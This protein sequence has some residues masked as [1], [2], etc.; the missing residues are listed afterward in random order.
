MRGRGM[1]RLTRVIF[2]IVLV[3]TVLAGLAIL[4]TTVHSLFGGYFWHPL[5]GDGYQFWS[6]IGSDVGEITMVTALYIWIKTHNCHVRG[7]WR[8]KWH[9]HPDHGHPVCRRHHPHS[10]SITED[11]L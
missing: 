11:G 6:G 4:G 2:F 10:D 8:L 9:G 5:A 1:R 7:C 3:P